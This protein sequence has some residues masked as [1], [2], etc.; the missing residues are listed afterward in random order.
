MSS[1][2]VI[3]MT[4]DRCLPSKSNQFYRNNASKGLSNNN[5]E[6][7]N[8]IN[9]NKNNKSENIKF[10]ESKSTPFSNKSQ[11]NNG[12]FD[13][14]NDSKNALNDW[15]KNDT[16]NF[17]E[18][19][20]TQEMIM[21]KWETKVEKDCNKS[22]L[23]LPIEAYENLIKNNSVE[24]AS[25]ASFD[26]LK[27]Q[28]KELMNPEI[29]QFKTSQKLLNSMHF[30]AR[31]LLSSDVRVRFAP[32]PTGKLHLG[33]LRTALFNFLFARKHGGS[34]ILRI[35]DTDVARTIPGCAEKFE[36]ILDGF[37]L[38]RDE[39]P[40]VGG[41]YGPYVQTQRKD[42]YG[43][44][45]QRLIESG[46]AYRCFCTSERLE[47]LRKNAFRKQEIPRYDNR[48]RS[49]SKEESAA[50]ERDAQPYV[51]RFK[52]NR[53]TVKFN[54]I[55]FGENVQTADEGDF[56]IIK[57]DGLPT[58]H[59]ANV[60]DDQFMKI[61]HVIRGAEWIPSCPKHIKLYESFKWTPPTFLHLPLITKDGHKKLSKRDNSAFVEYYTQEKVYLPLAILNYL[62]RNGSGLRDYKNDY[63]YSLEEMIKNFDENTIGTRDFMTDKNSLEKY[64]RL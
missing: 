26:F 51:I 14:K 55:V 37:G 31:R 6:Q 24:F 21:N 36:E 4:K 44:A 29:M 11:K 64:G 3:L 61:S 19:L 43:E 60:V 58:Y 28:N 49:L 16:P 18:S 40:L 7:F 8:S 53:E 42:L 13:Y 2:R 27:Q 54:D 30:T 57:S 45:A 12:F 39:S 10:V 62:L 63:C 52:F 22:P 1:K 34:F 46:H 38:R 17:H 15:K 9:L 47:I 33:G 35:E 5:N 50:R 23:S 59:F 32:S 41:E 20:K 25:K 48:C 56:I